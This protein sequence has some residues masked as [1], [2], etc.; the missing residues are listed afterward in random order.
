MRFGKKV[1]LR[2]TTKIVS[3]TILN[4]HTIQQYAITTKVSCN[5]KES[6]D[7]K[8]RRIAQKLSFI[9]SHPRSCLP[10]G[11]FSITQI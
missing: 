11:S 4:T 6:S 3:H 2:I 8:L 9:Q 7:R 5:Y 10:C 1:Q